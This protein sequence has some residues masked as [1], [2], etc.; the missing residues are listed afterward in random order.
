MWVGVHFRGLLEVFETITRRE[1]K[2]EVGGVDSEERLTG[3]GRERI[4]FE[5]GG[6]EFPYGTTE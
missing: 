1:R 4:I 5:M 3:G 2:R 6:G